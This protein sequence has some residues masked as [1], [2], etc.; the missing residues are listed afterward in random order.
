MFYLVIFQLR[1]SLYL[2]NSHWVGLR[3]GV[4]M[5]MTPWSGGTSCREDDLH[6]IIKPEWKQPRKK[7]YDEPKGLVGFWGR[8]CDLDSLS[9]KDPSLITVVGICLELNVRG[10]CCLFGICRYTF[11]RSALEN[12]AQLNSVVVGRPWI[13]T[14]QRRATNHM[15]LWSTRDV[16]GA[17]EGLS[18]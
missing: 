14:G 8:N 4:Q 3:E 13:C 15:G 9:G 16:A 6:I 11:R 7:K 10:N 17:P 1:L 5:T 2:R 18:F 12:G